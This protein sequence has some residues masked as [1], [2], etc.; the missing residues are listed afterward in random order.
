MFPLAAGLAKLGNDVTIITTNESFSILRKVAYE[1]NVRIII[2]PEII[3]SRVSRL[4]FGFLSLIRKI[5]FVLLHKFDIVQT[6]NGHRPLAGVPC[7]IH[8]RLWKSIYVAE[9]YDWY[10]VGGQYDTKQR[11]FKM[12]LGRYEL[13]WELKDKIVADG[14][15]VLSEVLRQRAQT[16]DMHKKII[17]LHGGADVSNIP[18]LHD[19]SQLKE[20]YGIDKNTLTFGYIDAFSGTLVE[21]QPLIDAILKANCDSMVKI[22]LFGRTDAVENT[23]SERVRKFIM[24]IGWVDYARDY[25]KLQ[26]VDVY[27]TFKQYVLG[28]RAGWPNCIGDY[29][30]C[31][32]PVFLNP[33]GEVEEFVKEYPAGFIVSSLDEPSIEKNVL[34]ILKSQD[35]L[36]KMGRINRNIAE[37]KISWDCKS[38]NLLEFYYELQKLNVQ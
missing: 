10:G 3:P 32:R 34:H 17:K 6:D 15:V 27:F 12:L 20:K 33:I 26:L 7:R 28:N 4:G 25:E 19:N 38:Q 5:L 36:K 37:T 29:M 1:D 30:A 31:G 35:E 18:Y 9:W 11:L 2:F 8:K 23:M 24:N 16:L 21:V 14:V 13:K 22:L